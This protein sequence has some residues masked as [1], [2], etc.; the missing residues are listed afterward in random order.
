M[1]KKNDKPV[2]G[3]RN[4]PV[5]NKIVKDYFVNNNY[6][7]ICFYD[8]KSEDMN[9][10]SVYKYLYSSKMSK[11]YW[12]CDNYPHTIYLNYISKINMDFY[13]LKLSQ[14]WSEKFI[15]RGLIK[16]DL[17][18]IKNHQFTNS[19]FDLRLLK[20]Q[21]NQ[22]IQ[23]MC[24]DELKNLELDDIP[25]YDQLMSDVN[26]E[27]VKGYELLNKL[28]MNGSDKSEETYTETDSDQ[29]INR[30][31]KPKITRSKQNQQMIARAVN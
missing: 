31:S 14:N 19:K 9:F 30:V 20:N 26:D 29:I 11:K 24:I 2:W 13:N 1:V 28:N 21:I 22:V 4:G 3:F 25:D 16:I 15:P 27:L 5:L 6:K 10:Y 12:N 8:P 23:N 7:I 18:K 17:E